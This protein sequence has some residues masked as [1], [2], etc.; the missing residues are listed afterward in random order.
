MQLS[1]FTVAVLPNC[2]Q[3]LFF[4]NIKNRLWQTTLAHFS[5]LIK[6]YCFT[7]KEQSSLS[8]KQE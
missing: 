6:L 2:H 7:Y 4:M 1:G 3:I 5:S 8:F